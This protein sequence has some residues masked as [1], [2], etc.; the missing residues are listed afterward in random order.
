M[1]APATSQHVTPEDALAASPAEDLRA[2][3]LINTL[4]GFDTTS[5][6]SNLAL[7]EWVRDYLAGHDVDSALTFDD[8]EGKANLF[9]DPPGPGRQYVDGWHRAVGPYR[10]CA[11]GRSGVG[12]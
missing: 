1:N 4:I 10:C 8:D 3:S 9:A 7:I 2:W 12:Q 11:R 5:R 6:D